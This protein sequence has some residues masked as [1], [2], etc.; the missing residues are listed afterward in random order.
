[1]LTAKD[2]LASTHYVDLVSV[3]ASGLSLL[4]LRAVVASL[5][6]TLKIDT[7][8]GEKQAWAKIFMGAL[9]AMLGK[10]PNGLLQPGAERH[11]YYSGN[12][13]GLTRT[14][15]WSAGKQRSS[16]H[17]CRGQPQQKRRHRRLRGALQ[18]A[19]RPFAKLAFMA[20]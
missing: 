6:E 3:N 14:C 9:R 10:E 17:P 8:K 16:P 7:A 1:M 13:A 12:V 20:A 4:E 19:R 2:E 18:S 15:L 5:P 11:P